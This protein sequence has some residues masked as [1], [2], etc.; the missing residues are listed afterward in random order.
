LAPE[1][2]FFTNDFAIARDFTITVYFP[3]V[4]G[5]EVQVI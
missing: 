4:L 1:K 5:K 3:S 2:M